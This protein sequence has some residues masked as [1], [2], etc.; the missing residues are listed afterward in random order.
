MFSLLARLGLLGSLI[1]GYIILC[2]LELTSFIKIEGIFESLSSILDNFFKLCGFKEE[3][4][5]A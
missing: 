4:A 3:K 1:F 2:Q 5:K